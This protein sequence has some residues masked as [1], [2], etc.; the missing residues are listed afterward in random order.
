MCLSYARFTM[1]D[2]SLAASGALDTFRSLGMGVVNAAPVA[3]G[4]LTM[5]GPP[6]WH[7]ARGPLREASRKA[8]AYCEEK[9]LDL[10]RL[11]FLHSMEI[12]RSSDEGEGMTVMVSTANVARN[13]SNLA[14]GTGDAPLTEAEQEAIAHIREHYF[15]P[16]EADREHMWEGEELQRYWERLGKHLLLQKLYPSF[17]EAQ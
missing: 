16:L 5:H 1:H 10:G 13:R 14:M 3:M 12:S 15:I 17:A 7:P 6:D 2:T 4:V 11:A 9:G 8:A